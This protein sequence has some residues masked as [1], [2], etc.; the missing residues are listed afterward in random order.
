L[1]AGVV[2]D[3]AQTRRYGSLIETEGRRLTEMIEQV[4]DYAN[5]GP[6]GRLGQRGIRDVRPVV[7]E[8][9]E[10]CAPLL[11]ERGIVAEVTMAAEVP[12]VAADETAVRRAVQNMV[13]NVLKY[14]VSGGWMAVSVQ[15]ATWR[16]RPGVEIAVRDRGPGVP[17]AEIAHVFEPFYRCRSAIDQQIQGSGLGL[18]LVKRIAEAHGGGVSVTSAAGEGA[19]FVFFLPAF[20]IPRTLHAVGKRGRPAPEPGTPG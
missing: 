13:S 17:A 11:A 14:A 8:V 10:S 3:P 6:D 16:G 7:K 4:L 9:L 12:V 19:T 5:L 15:P 2:H 20:V 18:S 1:S